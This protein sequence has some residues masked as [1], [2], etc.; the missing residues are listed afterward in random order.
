MFHGA[1]PITFKN[2]KRL[3]E[4]MTVAEKILWNHLRKR[5]L[6][7]TRFKRQHPIGLYIVDFYCHAAKL[8]IEVDG[9]I[10]NSDERIVYDRLRTHELEALGLKVLRFS[11]NRVIHEIENVIDEIKNNLTR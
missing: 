2:A 5:Q 7:N 11:N 6:N 4:E 8:V 9:E 1:V 3:R 10:H